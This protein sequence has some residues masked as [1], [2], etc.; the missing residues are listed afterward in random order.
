MIPLNLLNQV[1][2]KWAIGAVIV[3]AAFFWHN[4]QVDDL[5]YDTEQKIVSVYNEKLIQL[6]N[7]VDIAN[8]E[9]TTKLKEQE[10]AKQIEIASINSA[11]ASI[12]AS[13]QKRTNRR[14]SESNSSNCTGTEEAPVG[15]TGMQLSGLDAEV[16]ARFSRDTAELQSEMKSCILQ[17][18]IVKESVEALTNGTK[19]TTTN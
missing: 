14:A 9:L 4:K 13:L 19:Q 7:K 8:A 10:D 15:A 6:Q 11:H 17:Y 16:L 18:S 2:I 12:V 5:V 3:V 1:W